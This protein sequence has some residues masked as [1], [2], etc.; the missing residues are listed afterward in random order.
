MNNILYSF[1][2]T[3]LAGLSTL[4]GYFIVFLKVK[5]A[6]IIAFSLSFASGVMLTISVID[7]LPSAFIYL[8]SYYFIFR[9]LL[10]AFFF[11]LGIF[12]SSFI[13]QRVEKENTNSLKKVGIVSIIG[14]IL[15]R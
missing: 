10:I 5:K 12:F 4:L 7:L 13:N 9:I 11:I 15:N 8:K 2:L 1:I 3:L 6:K 14:I